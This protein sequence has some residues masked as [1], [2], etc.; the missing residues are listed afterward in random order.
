MLSLLPV[1][2]IGLYLISFFVDTASIKYISI[3][4][5]G[6]WKHPTPIIITLNLSVSIL[7]LMKNGYWLSFSMFFLYLDIVFTLRNFREQI[8]CYIKIKYNISRSA[9]RTIAN[10]YSVLR[11]WYFVFW[12]SCILL[13]NG[14]LWYKYFLNCTCTYTVF[15]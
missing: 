3:E 12:I 11:L 8:H 2:A 7:I 10:L 6:N 15:V 4:I 14:S 1:I 9:R 5:D 13:F